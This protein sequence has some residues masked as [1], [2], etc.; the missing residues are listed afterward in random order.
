MSFYNSWYH[1]ET[2]EFADGTV[3][4]INLNTSTFVID[5]EGTTVTVEQTNAEYLANLYTNDVFT[6]ELKTDNTVIAEVTNSISISEESDDI[7][8]ITN[9]QA[10]LLAENMSAFGCE[11]QIYNGIDPGEMTTETSALDQLLI[12]TSMQ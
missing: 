1:I 8:D 2:F 5:I 10:M 12:N 7:A 3:A 9:I 6:R 11:S 4:H